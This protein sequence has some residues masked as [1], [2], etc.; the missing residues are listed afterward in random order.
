VQELRGRLHAQLAAL[1]EIQA[2]HEAFLAERGA[3]LVDGAASVGTAWE[4]R[5]AEP[6]RLV[7]L[8]IAR[9]ATEGAA[10]VRAWA[11]R[12]GQGDHQL[13]RIA[14]VLAPPAEDADARCDACL[15]GLLALH[16]L[17]RVGGGDLGG[18]EQ[19]VEL[20]QMSANVENAFSDR[21]RAR[22][23]L[24]GLQLHHFGAFYKGSWRANDWLWGRLDGAAWLARILLDP[25]RLRR[26]VQEG[27]LQGSADAAA[28]IAAIVGDAVTDEE[29][30]AILARWSEQ[31]LAEE[32]AF[33]DTDARPPAQLER[34]WGA[35]TRALQY[36][37][38]REELPALVR[39]VRSD[40][41]RGWF[42]G[43]GAEWAD[44]LQEPLTPAGALEAFVACEIPDELI[45]DEVGSDHFN[46]FAE[47]TVR[48]A[49]GV[50]G[51]A[52]SGLPSFASSVADTL[53]KPA[54]LLEETLDV[55]ARA[56][57]AW[58]RVRFWK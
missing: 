3:A 5:H 54:V 15:Q 51:G 2:S 21:A 11:E 56:R 12:E 41:E 43:R 37:I 33:L 4:E 35:L 44:A 46:D 23:K 32:L 53:A 27:R 13:V 36:P 39:A 1:R 14:G 26:L 38:M 9:I 24:A 22:R 8:E 55:R 19:A 28:R 58:R 45:G 52:A 40:G 30:R 34:C 17:Q 49:L 57:G 48:V 10:I 50:A 16:V 31:E 7:A 25:A 29:E 20:V 42:R 18:I 47:K 6:L